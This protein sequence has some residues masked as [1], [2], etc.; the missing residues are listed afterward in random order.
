M[1]HWGPSGP[2]AGAASAGAGGVRTALAGPS[3]GWAYSSWVTGAPSST[4]PPSAAANAVARGL[5]AEAH[6]ASGRVVLTRRGR[7]LADAVVRELTG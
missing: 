4:Q 7:L 1:A 3:P 2:V 6:Y 5:A